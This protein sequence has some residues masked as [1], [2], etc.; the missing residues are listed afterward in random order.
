MRRA[1][2]FPSPLRRHPPMS[3]ALAGG[4]MAEWVNENVAL[5]FFVP[6]AGPS[7]GAGRGG[8]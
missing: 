2:S 5:C 1:A 3:P 7:R 6:R 8:V 4:D